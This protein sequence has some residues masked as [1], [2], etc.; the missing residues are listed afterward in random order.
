MAWPHHQ[1]QLR[2]GIMTKRCERGPAPMHSDRAK[3]SLIWLAKAAIALE[4]FLSIGA[5]GGGRRVDAGA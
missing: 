4:I 3:P 5:L 2:A 1:T